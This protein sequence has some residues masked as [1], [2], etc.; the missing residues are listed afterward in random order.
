[1]LKSYEYKGKDIDDA[2]AKALKALGLERDDVS[3]EVLERQKSGFL[4]IGAQ[5]ARIRVSY[6]DGEPEPAPEKPKTTQKPLFNVS[7]EK[8]DQLASEKPAG[9]EEKGETP[10]D[11]TTGEAPKLYAKIPADKSKAL[12]TPARSEH[13]GERSDRSGRGDRRHGER[14]EKAPAEPFVKLPVSD[15]EPIPFISGLLDRMGIENNA[16]ITER[17]EGAVKVSL[18]GPNMGRLIGRHGETMDSIQYISSLAYNRHTEGHTRVIIDTENYREKREHTLDHLAHRMAEN[19]LRQNRPV[20]LEPMSPTERRLIHTALQ[21]NDKVTTYSVGVDP[22]RRVVICPVGCEAEPVEAPSSGNR[23]NRGHRGGRN[24]RNSRS[25]G[26]SNARQ[27][28]ASAPAAEPAG[29]PSA[30]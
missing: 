30:E 9:R 19:A 15:E 21:D 22:C 17:T 7:K 26:R 2:I 24:H 5:D 27:N 25:G 28:E 11:P 8:L 14:R 18:S 1:M 10:K 12:P 23:R 29:E 20:T 16:E 4:G 6:D 13:R 3:V